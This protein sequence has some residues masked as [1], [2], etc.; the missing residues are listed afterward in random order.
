MLLCC[1]ACPT[2]S[3]AHAAHTCRGCSL[4]SASALW[5]GGYHQLLLSASHAASCMVS[6]LPEAAAVSCHLD[7]LF[8]CKEIQLIEFFIYLFIEE[9]PTGAQGSKAE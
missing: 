5:Q 6:P 3:S 1:A 8:I 4:S 2:K 7:I 9:S